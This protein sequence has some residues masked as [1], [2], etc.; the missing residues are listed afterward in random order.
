MQYMEIINNPKVLKTLEGLFNKTGLLGPLKKIPFVQ[1]KLKKQQDDLIQKLEKSIHPYK[2]KVQSFK[3]LP[4]EGKSYEEVL[5][6]MSDLA[7]QESSA[8]KEGKVSGAVYHGG[9]EHIDFLNK[10]YGLHSQCNPLHSDIWPSMAKYE[11]EI[12]S[13]V[14]KLFKGEGAGSSAKDEEICG[15]LTSGGTESIL[16]AMKVYRDQA[17]EK[18]GITRPEILLPLSAHAAFDKACHF[19][20]IKKKVVK[21]DDDLGVDLKDLAK[22]ITKNTICMVASAP[23]FAHGVMDPIEQ[24]NQLALK[25]KIPLHVD[26]CLGGL[27]LPF[28]KKLGH[29]LPQFDFSLKGVTSL[30]VDTHKYGYSAKGSSVILYR[31]KE[32]RQ[33]QYFTI[34]DWPGGLYFSPTL[35]G[36]RSG[37]LSA[38]CWAS[39]VSLGEEG[40]LENTRKILRAAKKIKKGIESIYGLRV[41]GDPLWVIAFTSE[42]KNIYQILDLMAQKGWHLNG[43]HRPEAIHICVTLPHTQ[44]GVADSFLR[45]LRDATRMASESE[46][47]EGMAPIYGLGAKVP[48]RGLVDDLMKGYLDELYRA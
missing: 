7:T 6:V 14:A 3:A 44:E 26:A 46:V 40:L 19:F 38:Q 41:L 10:V 25:H 9:A 12:I 15:T 13:M 8:W 17:L 36:S 27:I 39:L 18:K 29:S 20:K 2:D 30:S 43:L 28:A 11:A 45:D 21:L 47:K 33:Y 1:K 5:E 32:L 22:K 16:C 23:G 35:A 4:K 42:K 34:T 48:A 24:M 31:G 37:A